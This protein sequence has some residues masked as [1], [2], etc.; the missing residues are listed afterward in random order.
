[1]LR[2]C[3]VDKGSLLVRVPTDERLVFDPPIMNPTDPPEIP[4]PPQAGRPRFKGWLFVAVLLSPV[5]LTSLSVLLIDKKGDT[6]LAIAVLG[7]GLAGIIA[8]TMLGRHFGKTP[9]VKIG[10]SILFAAILGVV[11]ISMSCFG[12]LVS[13]YHLDFR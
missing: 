8:G 6:A 4:G 3:C 1:M 11:C 5:L 13:G 12:C 2:N 7:G 9:P 10:L